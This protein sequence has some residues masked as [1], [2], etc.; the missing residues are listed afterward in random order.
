[1]G[2]FGKAQKKKPY[3]YNDLIPEEGV[4]AAL[5]LQGTAHSCRFCTVKLPAG[6]SSICKHCLKRPEAKQLVEKA[7]RLLEK[8]T[9]KRYTDSEVL[10]AYRDKGQ[11]VLDIVD[12]FGLS[13]RSVYRILDKYNIPRRHNTWPLID[14]LVLKRII[15]KYQKMGHGGEGYRQEFIS[16]R[17][18]Y[19]LSQVSVLVR[20]LGISPKH[21]LNSK[22]KKFISENHEKMT[23]VDMGRHLHRTNGTIAR[24]LETIMAEG[25]PS[26]NI[27]DVVTLLGF[28]KHKVTQLI[29]SEM[30]VPASNT[31]HHYVITLE[32]IKE[33]LCSYPLEWSVG[34]VSKSFMIK[35]LRSNL[36][37]QKK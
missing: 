30:L 16:L 32:S 10:S 36:K 11:T 27:N 7:N 22:E 5:R 15:E 29:E 35:L 19:S 6:S 31:G 18:K 28:S 12:K 1:M 37:E 13:N 26:F 9:R 17:P 24:A 4:I 20:K 34:K 33:F 8:Q 3:R 21:L 23:I 2:T 25:S 14:I